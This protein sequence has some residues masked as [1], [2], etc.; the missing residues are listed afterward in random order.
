MA[1]L[2]L[3]ACF[4]ASAWT[5]DCILLHTRVRDSVLVTCF[6]LEYTQFSI[7][8]FIQPASSIIFPSHVRSARYLIEVLPLPYIASKYGRCAAGNETR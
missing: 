4:S 5:H 8:S 2:Y 3:L 1:G 6:V 7:V